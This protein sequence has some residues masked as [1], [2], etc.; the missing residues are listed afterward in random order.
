M[1]N[2]IVMFEKIVSERVVEEVMV[3]NACFVATRTLLQ[4]MASRGEHLHK[5]R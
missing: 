5:G 2:P 1:G 4:D 3:V